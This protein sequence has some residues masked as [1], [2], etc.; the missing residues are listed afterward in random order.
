MN[1]KKNLFVDFKAKEQFSLCGAHIYDRCKLRN[2]PH[3]MR[4]GKAIRSF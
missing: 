2:V 4:L 3:Q 1:I